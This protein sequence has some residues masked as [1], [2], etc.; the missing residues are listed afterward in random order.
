[1]LISYFYYFNIA[2]KIIANISGGDIETIN[3]L[4]RTLLGDNFVGIMEKW[5]RAIDPEPAAITLIYD[6]TN[7]TENPVSTFKTVL[8]GGV[9]LDTALQIYVPVMGMYD[10]SVTNLAQFPILI[11]P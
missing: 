7:V 3:G 9:S 5:N 10:P 1:L 2:S 4:G 6:Y 8:A 11:Q